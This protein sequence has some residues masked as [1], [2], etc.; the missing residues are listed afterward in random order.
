MTKAMTERMPEKGFQFD[1]IRWNYIGTGISIGS[2][3]G[4]LLAWGIG[5][6]W[7]TVLIPPAAGAIF[8][9]LLDIRHQ[10]KEV[11][12]LLTDIRAALRRGE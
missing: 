6:S 4:I 12:R 8:G 3:V 11:K 7:Q 2:L 10:I 5:V 9:A 1:F